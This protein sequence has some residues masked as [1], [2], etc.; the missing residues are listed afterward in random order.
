MTSSKGNEVAFN[1]YQKSTNISF[2]DK[3]CDSRISVQTFGMRWSNI[4]QLCTSIQCL[5]Q[6][7][8]WL[9]KGQ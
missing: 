9:P 3:Y 4:S 8:F 2:F 6:F 7:F 5:A 1:I